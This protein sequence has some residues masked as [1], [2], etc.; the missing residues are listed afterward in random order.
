MSD[1]DLV[2]KLQEDLPYQAVP[3]EARSLGAQIIARDRRRM[4]LLALVT[5]LLWAGGL[6]AVLYSVFCFNQFVIAFSPPPLAT[7]DEM[8]LIQAKMDLHHSLNWCMIG[9]PALLLAALGTVGLVL[10]SRRATLNQINLSLTE[11][12]GQLRRMHAA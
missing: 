5:A 12:S 6:T 9:L 10:S 8:R 1:Q 3:Q 7:V 11:I 4:R 2:R